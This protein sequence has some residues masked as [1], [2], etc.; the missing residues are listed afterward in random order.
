MNYNSALYETPSLPLSRPISQSHVVSHCFL[1]FLFI[2]AIVT[3]RDIACII[4]SITNMAT[5]SMAAALAAS[6]PAPVLP[7]AAPQPQVTKV[8]Q[9]L[10]GVVDPEAARDVESVKLNA[11]VS[12]TTGQH[13]V[14]HADE[15]AGL[16]E[17]A[18]ALD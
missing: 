12:D 18:Q 7:Q 11:L 4:Y 14:H 2:L 9:R 16:Y 17:D 5:Q 1:S 13:H 10:E 15:S 3:I 6:L 8:P